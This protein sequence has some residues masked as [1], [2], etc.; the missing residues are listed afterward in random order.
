MIW[1]PWMLKFLYGIVADSVP[2]FG[3]RK[4]GWILLWGCI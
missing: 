1:V 4:K 3:S 2:L